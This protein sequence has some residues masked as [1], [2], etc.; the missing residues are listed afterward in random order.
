M[1]SVPVPA[2]LEGPARLLAMGSVCCSEGVV[3]TR[4]LSCKVSCRIPNATPFSLTLLRR[5][6]SESFESSKGLLDSSFLLSSSS[7]LLSP[8]PQ[9]SS[10]LSEVILLRPELTAGV[11]GRDR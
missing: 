8:P 3:L 11:L 1:L 7:D 10:D 2:H 6:C 9:S 5:A 4:I